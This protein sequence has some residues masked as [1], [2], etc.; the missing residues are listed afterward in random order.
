MSFEKINKYIYNH[1]PEWYIA[2]LGEKTFTW[3]RGSKSSCI[4]R[5]IFNKAMKE[6]IN[7]T[8]ICSYFH[9]ISD[10]RH[11]ILSCKKYSSDNFKKPSKIFK[12]SKRLCNTKC[13]SI[14]SHNYFS[15]LADEL[16]A[17]QNNLSAEDMFKK[18]IDTSNSIGKDIKA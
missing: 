12:W 5:I 4:D 8:S 1:F 14:L 15:V 9:D 11:I 18:F 16:S 7:M 10:H 6:H 17:N 13:S 3:A 2:D